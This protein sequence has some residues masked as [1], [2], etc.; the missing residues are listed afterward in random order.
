MAEIG[1]VLKR[2]ET[3]F[4]GYAAA[5]IRQSGVHR[6]RWLGHPI[7]GRLLACQPDR[8]QPRPGEGI[9]VRQIIAIRVSH[10]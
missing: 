5:Q 10:Q 8:S 1:H 7:K 4:A 2:C 6:L 9:E 3:H